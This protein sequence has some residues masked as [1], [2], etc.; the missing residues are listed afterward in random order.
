M[1]DGYDVLDSRVLLRIRKKWATTLSLQDVLRS[2][3]DHLQLQVFVTVRIWIYVNAT[4]LTYA[5]TLPL[6]C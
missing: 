3:I 2:I 5:N 1:V 6:K 4:I